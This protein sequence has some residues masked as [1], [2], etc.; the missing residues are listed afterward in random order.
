[1]AKKYSRQ[2]E[3]IF[4]LLKSTNTH[5]TADWLYTQ[6]RERFPNISLATIY[7]NLAGFVVDGTAFSVSTVNGQERF[8]ANLEQHEHFICERC[9]AVYDI[10]IPCAEDAFDTLYKKFGFKVS[11]QKQ[12]FYGRCAECN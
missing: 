5:P 7:R 6:L 2:R 9:G 8:D 10:H 3:A 1:M 11:S 12:L 4:E